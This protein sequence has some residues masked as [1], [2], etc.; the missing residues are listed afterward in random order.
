MVVLMYKAF[1]CI[2]CKPNKSLVHTVQLLRSLS[3]LFSCDIVLIPS[4]T[5][6]PNPTELDDPFDDRG[7]G[8]ITCTIQNRSL[9][10]AVQRLYT[11]YLNVIYF[12]CSSFT[13]N[14]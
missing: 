1:G 13:F 4:M 6:H 12:Q 9:V 11:T 8:C 2:T 10:H 5:L 3:M 14:I 7:S